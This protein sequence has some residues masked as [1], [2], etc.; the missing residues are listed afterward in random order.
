[1]IETFCSFDIEMMEIM[2]L[3]LICFDIE[4]NILHER[5]REGCGKDEVLDGE[6]HSFSSL[7]SRMR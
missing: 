6:F 5:K 3:P 4:M 1:V 7:L 2:H